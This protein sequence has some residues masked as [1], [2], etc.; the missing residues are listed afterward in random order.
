MYMMYI[1]IIIHIIVFLL[2][3][4]SHSPDHPLI[5]ALQPELQGYGGDPGIEIR[6]IKYLNNLVEQ[7]HRGVIP[8][9]PSKYDH[10]QVI[11][12]RWA[13]RNNE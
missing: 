4:R 2:T 9:P 12:I 11:L 3:K 5:L 10:E 13:R 8:I 1:F 6:Q 7:D